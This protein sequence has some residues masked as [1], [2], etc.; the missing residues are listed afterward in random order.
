MLPESL[1][2][3]LHAAVAASRDRD[4]GDDPVGLSETSAPDKENERPAP[5]LFGSGPAADNGG[6]TSARPVPPFTLRSVA[7]QAGA[8]DAITQ[9]IPVI[10]DQVVAQP[11]AA[12]PAA[13]PADQQAA[14]PELAAGREVSAVQVHASDPETGAPQAP[15]EAGSR[16]AAKPRAAA[17]PPAPQPSPG[18]RAARPAVSGTTPGAEERKRRAH[19]VYRMAGLAVVLALAI[20]AGS[21]AALHHRG[22]AGPERLISSANLPPGIRNGAG[23]W[24]ASQIATGDTVACDP[25]MCRV[26][27]TDGMASARL[28]VLWPGSHDVSGCAVIV[29]TPVLQAELGA[30]LASVDAPAVIAR[31]GSGDRQIDVRAVAPRG[32]AGYRS[33]L[34]SDLTARRGAGA[35]LAGQAGAQLSAGEKKQLAAGQVD[36]RLIVVIAD[37]EAKQPVRVTALGDPSPGVGP[38][39][40]PLRSA[41]LIITSGA[42]Q[43]SILAEL[44]GVARDPRYRPARIDTVRFPGGETVLR[45]EFAAPSPLGLLG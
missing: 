7:E 2:E 36:A 22:H 38:A 28:R 34:D 29:A 27:Q 24:V 44:G 15:R 42:G 37:I 8:A 14:A 1:A 4:E 25:V 10:S 45:V 18:P 43:R 40:A 11:S 20:A 26:L 17:R 9:P 39:A 13:G 41:D 12:A 6:A 19:R 5:S 30:R 32:A 3:R 35:E 23:T 33:E 21:F 31:F 16:P